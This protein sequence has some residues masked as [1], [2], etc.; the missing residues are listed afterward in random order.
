[1]KRN[2]G[3]TLIELLIVVAIIGILAAIA[4]PNFLQAQVRAKVAST[5]AEMRT[6]ANALELYR[7]DN[8]QYPPM[9]EAGTWLWS[10]LTGN[11]AQF[12]SRVPSVLSTP[13]DY[14]TAI[15]Q[16]V[17]KDPERFSADPDWIQVIKRRYVYYNFPQYIDAGYGVQTRRQQAGDWLFYSWGPDKIDFN[18]S[19]G[20]SAYLNYDPTNGTVSLGNIFRTQKDPD[21]FSGPA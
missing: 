7:T 16:D 15:D 17:F 10:P 11:W 21:K 4:I 3:F 2:A 18:T 1:M 14:M 20:H 12:H 9:G 5:K 13:V 8:N 6:A 19:L